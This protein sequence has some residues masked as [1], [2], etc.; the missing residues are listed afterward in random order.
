MFELSICTGINRKIFGTGQQINGYR[1]KRTDEQQ[2]H[3][4]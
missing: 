4:L 2:T 3:V 1:T